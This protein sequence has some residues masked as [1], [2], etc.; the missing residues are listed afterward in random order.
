MFNC[1]NV[2]GDDWLRLAE[3]IKQTETRIKLWELEERRAERR[4]HRGNR[5]IDRRGLTKPDNIFEAMME[6]VETERLWVP[7]DKLQQDRA[8]LARLYE[9]RR[10]MLAST[11]GSEC[12]RG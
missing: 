3:L 12:E 2:V 4:W 5:E 9:L 10:Q 11:D 1:Q 8:L 6:V 7:E